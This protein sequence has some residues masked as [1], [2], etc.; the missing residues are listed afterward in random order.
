MTLRYI[1]QGASGSACE[2]HW[3]IPIGSVHS[4]G[5]VHWQILKRSSR[6]N[7]SVPELTGCCP[8]EGRNSAGG[9]EQVN[10]RAI[11]HKW[12][13]NRW[14]EQIIVAGR[15][16]K[17]SDRSDY[18]FTQSTR[19]ALTRAKHLRAAP[20]GVRAEWI[21][22]PCPA[23][24]RG[25]VNFASFINSWVVLPAGGQ[26]R[27]GCMCL[28]GMKMILYCFLTAML[29]SVWLGFISWLAIYP[30]NPNAADF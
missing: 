7:W 22:V 3:L 13:H 4:L 15:A 5:T 28:I 18:L 17:N 8:L 24:T 27:Y 12:V 25:L 9:R 23:T 6:F 21:N 2:P 26:Q 29:D 14:R 1:D 30:L 10:L 16:S 20:D 11:R 19:T